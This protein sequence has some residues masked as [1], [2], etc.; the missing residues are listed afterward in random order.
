MGS[1][2]VGK[3]SCGDVIK[4]QAQGMGQVGGQKSDAGAEKPHEP[5]D[6]VETTNHWGLDG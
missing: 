2:L 4:L 5:T 1:A 6:G 3:A